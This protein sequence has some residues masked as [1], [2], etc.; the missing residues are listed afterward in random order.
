MEYHPD[1]NPEDPGTAAET[2]R[3]LVDAFQVLSGGYKKGKYEKEYQ[4][5]QRLQKRQQQQT[6]LVE[7]ATEEQEQKLSNNLSTILPNHLYKKLAQ[8]SASD[9]PSLLPIQN[10][11]YQK[12]LMGEN[13]VLNAPSGSGKT[14]GY[15]LPLLA[16]LPE[17]KE[18]NDELNTIQLEQK[19]GRRR[20]RRSRQSGKKHSQ[21]CKPINLIL[22]PSKEVA[23]KVG[24]VCS[25]YHQNSKNVGIVFGPK[26]SNLWRNAEWDTLVGTPLRIKELIEGGSLDL[27]RLQTVVWDE[28]DSMLDPDVKSRVE[29]VCIHFR[30][31]YQTIL[32]SAIMTEGVTAFCKEAMNLDPKDSN[33]I[34]LSSDEGNLSGMSRH[35]NPTILEPSIANLNQAEEEV[36]K[37]NHW[38]IATSTS[39]QCMVAFDII[40]SLQPA[41]CVVFV[42]SSAE[43]EVVTKALSFSNQVQTS[44][45]HNGMPEDAR[46]QTLR[47]WRD[48]NYNSTRISNLLVTTDDVQLNNL[49]L[50]GVDLVLHIGIPR[51]SGNHELYDAKLYRSRSELMRQSRDNNAK[52]YDEIL[53]Y[54]YEN[55]GRL[56]PGLQTEMEIDHGI[57]M[58]PRE[59]PVPQNVFESPYQHATGI[60]YSFPQTSL[61]VDNF[62][63]K[64]ANEMS[65]I[66]DEGR[67]QELVHRLAVA[68]AAL[69]DQETPTK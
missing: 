27:T 35:S 7:V 1:K 23:K 62:K 10:Q 26:Q 47:S 67:E 12:I 14:L 42:A 59:P 22:V 5:L 11:S 25:Q 2:F 21:P 63:E 64:V 68:L 55:E 29:D 66:T 41:L 65:E 15:L 8:R 6:S 3:Q 44:I 18:L 45:L 69:A 32:S 43:A 57:I 60:C 34:T 31:G 16:R 36:S 50:P 49:D 54:D 61:M 28:A 24:K 17:T 30:E 53:L 46:T 48:V 52:E 37:A 51:L 13:V 56:L 40:A 58:T 19:R 39:D 4:M 20:N 33:F 38:L 9:K